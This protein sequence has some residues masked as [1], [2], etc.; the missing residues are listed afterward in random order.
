MK[1][2]REVQFLNHAIVSAGPSSDEEYLSASS[3]L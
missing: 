2:Y 3:H 1:N